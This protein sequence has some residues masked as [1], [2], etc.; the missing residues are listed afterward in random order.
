MQHKTF[1]LFMLASILLTIQCKQVESGTPAHI[2][3]VTKAIDDNRLINADKTPGDW[4]SHGRNY[5]EDR[6]SI[7]EQINKGNVK[8]LGLAWTIN[9][10]TKRGIKRLPSL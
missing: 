4:L 8:R 3:K 9:L 6:Y 7:L 10:G 5:A 2:Q 1:Y